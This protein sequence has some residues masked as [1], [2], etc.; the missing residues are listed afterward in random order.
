MSS[1]PANSKRARHRRALAYQTGATLSLSQNSTLFVQ[2]TP[3]SPSK[4]HR[5]LSHKDRALLLIEEL[6][7]SPGGKAIIK[8]LADEHI[9]ITEYDSI[10]LRSRV[11]AETAREAI[12]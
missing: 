9:T 1:N 6:R 12:A 4:I 10:V 5:R 11:V 3:S 2:L 8:L 7:E